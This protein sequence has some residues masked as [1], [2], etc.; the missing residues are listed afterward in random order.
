MAFVMRVLPNGLLDPSFHGTGFVTTSF[1]APAATIAA[2]TLEPGGTVLAAGEA[3]SPVGKFALTRYHL[4]GGFLVE[5]PEHAALTNN[6]PEPVDFGTVAVGTRFREFIIRNE[7]AQPLTGLTVSLS[8][9]SHP[10]EFAIGPPALTTLPPGGTTTFTIAFTPTTTP[11]LRTATLHVRGHDAEERTFAI[12]LAGRRATPSEVWRYTWFGSYEN[13]GA[14]ADLNDFDHDG[15]VNLLEYALGTH[16]HQPAPP[17]VTLVKNGDVL[18]YTYTRP[19]ATLTELILQPES[20]PTP[21]GPWSAEAITT[22]VL[23]NDGVTQTVRA[24]I[25]AAA[26]ASGFVRLRVTRR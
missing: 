5:Q 8:G 18:E 7:E 14:A 25:P 10:G 13:S 1:D 17:P 21:A 26:A 3:R 19:V 4:T 24:I 9:E 2:V 22:T 15:V 6:S 23:S 11:G 12:T 16:P 20:A